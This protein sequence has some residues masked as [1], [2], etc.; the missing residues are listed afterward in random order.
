M[1]CPH[2]LSTI[3]LVICPATA[4]FTISNR[5]CNYSLASASF[6]TSI[7]HSEKS[8]S[9]DDRATQFN[10]RVIDGKPL[11]EEVIRLSNDFPTTQREKAIHDA[12]L[13]KKEH[14][15]REMAENMLSGVG[16]KLGGGEAAEIQAKLDRDVAKLQM[17]QDTPTG[18][19]ARAAYKREMGTE[20][21]KIKEYR[22]AAVHY[23]ESINLD[24]T[25]AAVWCN[26]AMCW[27]K[28]ADTTRCISDCDRCLTL[29]PN[30]VKALFRKG[31]A[32]VEQGTDAKAGEARPLFIDACKCF[33][34]VLEIDPR[35]APA[36]SS[37]ALAEK[38]MSM[39]R[40]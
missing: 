3:T 15:L 30:N 27:L 12:N 29:E 37:M 28:L 23:T 10:T 33:R 25:V 11:T 13:L 6:F 20:Q 39:L 16:S 8:L 14:A 4:T 35:N 17:E 19:A 7:L 2:L 26:R 9:S 21:F 1:S 18:D 5:T 40:D 38:K 22:Q 31:V 36:K 24:D 34:L 32:L